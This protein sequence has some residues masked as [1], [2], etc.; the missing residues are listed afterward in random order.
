MKRF[1]NNVLIAVS[2]ILFCSLSAWAE[3]P[4]APSSPKP[5]K[6]AVGQESVNFGEAASSTTKTGLYFFAAILAGFGLWK[7]LDQKR[8]S[9]KRAPIRII[10]KTATSPRTALVLAEVEGRK[11]LL[12][13]GVENLSLISELEN[14]TKDFHEGDFHEVLDEEFMKVSNEK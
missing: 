12:A 5:F 10:G 2:I 4:S 3:E 11:F 9:S 7:H 6:F 13:Q 8:S 1:L 14:S